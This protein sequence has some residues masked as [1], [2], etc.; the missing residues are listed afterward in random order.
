MTT[1][2]MKRKYMVAAI[3][4]SSFGGFASPFSCLASPIEYMTCEANGYINQNDYEKL[5]KEL[6]EQQKLCLVSIT[7]V[8]DKEQ[9]Q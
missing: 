4:S 2:V 1:E 9:E 8:T 3:S 5:V 6:W 7:D